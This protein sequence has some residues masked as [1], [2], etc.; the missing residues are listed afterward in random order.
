[1]NSSQAHS[2]HSRAKGLT[3]LEVLKFLNKVFNQSPYFFASRLSEVS[4]DFSSFP[5]GLDLGN[6]WEVYQATASKRHEMKRNIA[7]RNWIKCIPLVQSSASASLQKLLIL[8]IPFKWLIDWLTYKWNNFLKT[9]CETSWDGEQQCDM[10]LM[11]VYMHNGLLQPV[12]QRKPILKC[13]SC[14]LPRIKNSNESELNINILEHQH[15]STR[16]PISLKSWHQ[17]CGFFPCS[18]QKQTRFS[19]IR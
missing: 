10:I 14:G 17:K 11:I 5:S 7:S 15:I 4:I 3:W 8:S 13:D 18:T 9:P 2:N 6:N 16:N 12:L 1:M 19:P